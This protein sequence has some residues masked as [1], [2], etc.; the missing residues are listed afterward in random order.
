MFSKVLIFI[1]A[2]YT[3]KIYLILQ[4]SVSR[5]TRVLP[6]STYALTKNIEKFEASHRVKG[7]YDFMCSVGRSFQDYYDG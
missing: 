6:L 1:H 3:L 5:I 4:L 2:R 7:P